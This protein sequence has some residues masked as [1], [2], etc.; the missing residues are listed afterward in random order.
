MCELTE[1]DLIWNR[2]C[3]GGGS[4][5]GRGDRALAA[6]LRAHNLA[7]NGGVLDAVECLS[8]SELADAESGYRF[9]GFDSAADLMSRARHLSEGDT[10]SGPRLLV[11]FIFRL[12]RLFKADDDLESRESALDAEYVSIIPGDSALVERFQEYWSAHPSDFAPV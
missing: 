10:G 8:S 9:F 7:M 5:P 3:E 4:G 6:L 1:A 11:R 2:A 12:R